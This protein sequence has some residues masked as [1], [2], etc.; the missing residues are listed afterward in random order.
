M[1][2]QKGFANIVLIVLVVVLAGVVGY[3]VFVKKS[4]PVSQQPTPIQ[5]Q[6]D[7]SVNTPTPSTTTSSPT[8]TKITILV[9]DNVTA[10]NKAMTEYIQGGGQNPLKNWVFVKKE[11]S[12][13]YTTDIVKASAEAAAEE[14]T[15]YGGPAKTSIAYLKIQDGTAYALLDID[16]DGWAGVSVSIG[17]IHPLVEKTLLQFPQI[18][19]VVF[20]FAPGDTL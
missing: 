13:P 5:S 9:P 12:I 8:Q 3:F 11:L 10:Y 16:L 1:N 15:P 18:K 4:E 17:R 7:N 19:N 6:A 14:L 20:G 2:Q